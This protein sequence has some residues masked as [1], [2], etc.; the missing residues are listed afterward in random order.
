[1]M[2]MSSTVEAGS[3]APRPFNIGNN[4][5]KTKSARKAVTASVATKMMAG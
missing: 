4:L 1:M 3:F 5:G 2:V